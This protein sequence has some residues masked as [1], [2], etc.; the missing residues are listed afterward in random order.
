MRWLFTFSITF[1]SFFYSPAQNIT[2]IWRGTFEQ[3]TLD[4]RLGKFSKESYRY[5]VQINQLPKGELEGVTYSYLTTVFYGKASLKGIFD[6][7]RK[8]L[9]IKETVLLDVK[10]SAGR[11]DA[12]L[13][14]CY[15]DY[16][17]SGKIENL[18]GTY[19]SINMKTKADC[20]YGT[21]FLEKV[22]ESDFELEDFLKK[23][24]AVIAKK[25]TSKISTFPRTI[26]PNN[27]NNP[28][29]KPNVSENIVA[30]K[31]IPQNKKSNNLPK[32]FT[33]DI[34]QKQN[35]SDFITKN[36][37][38]ENIDTT[39]TKNKIDS[40][41]TIIS[42]DSKII[43]EPNTNVL[44]VRENKLANKIYID[45]KDVYIEFYDNGEIDNDSISVYL[46]NKLIINNE[47]LSTNPIKLNLSFDE[48]NSFYEIIIVAENLGD[49]PPNTAL[50]VINYGR[51]RQEVFLTSD[52]KRNAKVILEY[53]EAK[54]LSY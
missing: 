39:P 11:T 2:G 40:E 20:G 17:K 32:P 46:D 37:Y 42:K 34:E 51:K 43:P 52:D 8:I 26:S 27:A 10:T 25:N 36:N 30:S 50:M 28:K 23:P 53:K 48:K 38:I 44:K 24:N 21:V 7:K 41:K 33:P 16:S 49:I 1:F 5:E 29:V 9:T 13:M 18:I 54:K 3:K 47:R 4:A 35:K 45:T 6:K 14:T 31:P 19:T 22:N 12:C 15:L